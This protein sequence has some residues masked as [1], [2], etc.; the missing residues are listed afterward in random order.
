MDKCEG[1][2]EIDSGPCSVC[3]AMPS[4]RC[5]RPGPDPRDKRIAELEA[6]LDKWTAGA[7]RDKRIAELEQHIVKQG[8]EF[9]TLTE[10]YL[11]LEQENERLREIVQGSKTI[12]LERAAEIAESLRV[13]G[14]P[15]SQH[16][17]AEA[18]RAE[19]EDTDLEG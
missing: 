10:R 5:R 1:G 11:E 7:C 16:W 19:I 15:A 12:W 2:V 8:D 4:D 3:G 13:N 9:S 14:G 6:T 17:V 18:I